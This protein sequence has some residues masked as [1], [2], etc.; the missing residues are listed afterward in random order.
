MHQKAKRRLA[1][2]YK[3]YLQN[4]GGVFIVSGGNVHPNLTPHNEAME[5]KRY[6]ME[7]FQVSEEMIIID[8]YA[9]HST[10][11]IRNVG[12]FILSHGLNRA[13]IVSSI[14]QSLYFSLPHISSFNS[15]LRRELGH[16]VGRLRVGGYNRS[17]F[18]PDNINFTVGSDPLDP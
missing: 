14:D 11:N 17:Q 9:R 6:L 12:R 1:W 15:R 10:T 7:H 18:F 4:G 3:S 8:P 5:M 2:G 16:L 13:L